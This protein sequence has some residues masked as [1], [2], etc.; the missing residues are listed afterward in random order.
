[1]V[2]TPELKSSL[3]CILPRVHAL[4]HRW[5]LDNKQGEHVTHKS[6]ALTVIQRVSSLGVD[7]LEAA[8]RVLFGTARIVR[9]SGRGGALSKFGIA[10]ALGSVCCTFRLGQSARFSLF[11]AILYYNLL[12]IARHCVGLKSKFISCA[13]FVCML[14][15]A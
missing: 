9:A 14:L 1:M 5:L 2:C 8:T 4:R 3:E 13:V 15:S 10:R 6:G 7:G 12:F 11:G